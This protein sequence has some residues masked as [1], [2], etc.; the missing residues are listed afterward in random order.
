MMALVE[1]GGDRQ[2]T[3]PGKS[4]FLNI[5][6]QTDGHALLHEAV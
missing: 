6:M 3:H 1:K 4:S 5:V 2:E